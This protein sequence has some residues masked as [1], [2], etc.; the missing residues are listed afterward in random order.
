MKTDIFQYRIKSTQRN[1][2]ELGPCECCNQHVSEVRL[3]TMRQL[4]ISAWDGRSFWAGGSHT[5]GHLKCLQEK[6]LLKN[7]T[8][9]G[10]GQ[11]VQPVQ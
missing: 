10:F 3:M 4:C 8:P 5:F 1:S 9:W 7:A 2:S 11:V 6:A